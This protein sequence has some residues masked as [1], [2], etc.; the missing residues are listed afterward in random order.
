MKNP[1]E[2]WWGF[3]NGHLEEGESTEEA[4]I[5]EVEEET[6]I[7]AEIVEKIGQSKYVITKNNQ[8]IFKVV[9]IFL[10][11]YVAGEPKAQIGEVS[12]VIWL[13]YEEAFKKLT[14]PGD[15]DLLKKAKELM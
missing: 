11:K 6:G 10:M 13:P 3:P 7:K 9:T 4:A 1:E 14:Y 12:D 5:R 2:K 8:K 15:K